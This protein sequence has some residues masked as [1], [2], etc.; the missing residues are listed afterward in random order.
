MGAQPVLYSKSV[1]NIFCFIILGISL[2]GLALRHLMK[3]LPPHTVLCN[4]SE[5][6]KDLYQLAQKNITGGPSIIFTRY[7]KA[8]K[9][10]IRDSPNKCK[11]I[12][13]LDCN[14][15]YL[16]TFQG[17]QPNGLGAR[18]DRDATTLNLVRKDMH[19]KWQHA[20]YEWLSWVEHEQAIKIQHQFNGGQVKIGSFTVDGFGVC[21]SGLLYPGTLELTAKLT[22]TSVEVNSS[23]FRSTLNSIASIIIFGARS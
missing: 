10:Y 21:Q 19:P 18:W 20:E 15:L 6:N 5:D 14:S 11:S 1:F 3:D 13:G 16:S 4:E 23:C 12:I 9:T 22:G 17:Q 8:G 2:P 7:H